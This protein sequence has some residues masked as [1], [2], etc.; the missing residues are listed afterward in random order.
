MIDEKSVIKTRVDIETKFAFQAVAV[1]QG[2]SEA[3]LLQ[4]LVSTFLRSNSLEG[5]SVAPTELK[6]ERFSF[7]LH[8]KL[9]QD[10]SKRAAKQGMSPSSYVVAMI[11]AH[12]SQKPYFTQPELVALVQSRYELSATGR[13]LNQIARALNT[14]LDNADL[15]RAA[16]IEQVRHDV[17]KFRE[18]VDALVLANVAGW[19]I[20]RTKEKL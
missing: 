7:R 16:E 4:L 11:R 12:L 14:S 15:A 20:Q 3:R 6:N 5:E 19:G 1:R 2:T 9:K 8:A 17:M 18:V 13:N 10:L